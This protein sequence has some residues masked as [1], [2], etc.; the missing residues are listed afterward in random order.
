MKKV[1]KI[2]HLTKKELANL[3]ESHHLYSYNSKN[4]YKYSSYDEIQKLM[5]Q[6]KAELIYEAM[7]LYTFE[8]DGNGNYKVYEHLMHGLA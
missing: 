1:T 4:Y 7:W 8:F 5:K 2:E 6:S 3:I